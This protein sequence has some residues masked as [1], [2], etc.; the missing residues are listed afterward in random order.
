MNR[1]AVTPNNL[2]AYLDQVMTAENYHL[3]YG[4]S[5]LT[6]TQFNT[7][8]D[9]LLNG[10]TRPE[11]LVRLGSFTVAE[12]DT[13]IRDT[14]GAWTRLG[15]GSQ[16]AGTAGWTYLAD[17]LG[18][19][20]LLVE[21][22]RV[23]SPLVPPHRVLLT[24]LLG[25]GMG[26]PSVQEVCLTFRDRV[27]PGALSASGLTTLEEV[28][29]SSQAA[30]DAL[31]VPGT[32]PDRV[33]QF[34]TWL[35]GAFAPLLDP[36]PTVDTL[37]SALFA[38]GRDMSVLQLNPGMTQFI[39]GDTRPHGD[40]QLQLQREAAVRSSLGPLS[41]TDASVIL[42]RIQA[43]PLTV[44][45]TGV[46]VAGL[47]FYLRVVGAA[48]TAAPTDDAAWGAV[49]LHHASLKDS[50]QALF[51]Y[52]DRLRAFITEAYGRLPSVL[53]GSFPP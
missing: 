35:M 46:T 31:P 47:D 3:L 11:D 39:L 34:Q 23:Q 37:C 45:A 25:G 33:T 44:A 10:E 28:F 50:L 14:L 40:T 36:A 26:Q 29:P 32:T 1:V 8:A 41:A 5:L 13:F 9:A 2:R 43:T 30:R 42:D 27:V 48:I 6:D 16:G 18:L 12:V 19:T 17:T 24:E 4:L 15:V 21:L 51:D 22:R 53:T 52:R 20:S 7:V 49:A 38:V